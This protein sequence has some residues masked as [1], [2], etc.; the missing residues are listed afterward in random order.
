[1]DRI[2]D[3]SNHHWIFNQENEGDDYPVVDDRHEI[4]KLIQTT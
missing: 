2:E 1:M 3:R 4:K